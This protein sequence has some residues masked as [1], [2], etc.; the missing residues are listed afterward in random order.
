MWHRRF[1]G[2]QARLTLG[3]SFPCPR[4]KNQISAPNKREDLFLWHRYQK[5][6]IITLQWK[7]N[8]FNERFIGIDS[9]GTGLWNADKKDFRYRCTP[10]SAELNM[11]KP[12]KNRIIIGKNQ[13]IFCLK[14]LHPKGETFQTKKVSIYLIINPF[15]EHFPIWILRNQD[16]EITKSSNYA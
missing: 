3:F 8:N 2:S 14:K 4:P 15:I 11:N 13:H 5:D 6:F 1:N 10:H 7:Q 12:S 16:T 9:S